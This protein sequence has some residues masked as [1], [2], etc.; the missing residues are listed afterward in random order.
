MDNLSFLGR[1]EYPESVNAKLAEVLDAALA[2]S[3]SER[4]EIA[5]ELIATLET[6]NESDGESFAELKTAVSVGVEQLDRNEGIE[7]PDGSL[8][9]YIHE[10]GQIATERA[11]RHSA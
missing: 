10:L 2:L 11:A 8:G 1:A 6:T 9:E 7:I 3:R 5:H 4:A